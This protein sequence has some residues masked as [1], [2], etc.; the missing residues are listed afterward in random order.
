MY[1]ERI[2][3]DYWL[4]YMAKST[5]LQFRTEQ[6]RLFEEGRDRNRSESRLAKRDRKRETEREERRRGRR[7]RERWRDWEAGNWKAILKMKEMKARHV[8]AC[9]HSWT[10][11]QEDQRTGNPAEAVSEDGEYIRVRVD[12]CWAAWGRRLTC[13]RRL[14][15]K[16]RWWNK[17]QT[18]TGMPWPVTPSTVHT[19]CWKQMYVFVFNLCKSG[20]FPFT[21]FRSIISLRALTFRRGGLGVAVAKAS[22]EMDQDPLSLLRLPHERKGF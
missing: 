20:L 21:M 4:C 18:D 14:R 11:I 9:V 17:C 6:M 5:A 10:H 3:D 15:W 7:E 8:T 19:N 2:C 22:W 1:R 16:Q 12:P 13:E